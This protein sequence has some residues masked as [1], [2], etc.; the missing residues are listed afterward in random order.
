MFV[1]FALFVFRVLYCI[2]QASMRCKLLLILF[3]FFRLPDATVWRVIRAISDAARSASRV[4]IVA[5]IPHSQHYRRVEQ[6]GSSPGLC[7]GGR[8]LESCPCNFTVIIS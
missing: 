5:L 3:V 7:P 2:L 4:Q 1:L 6:F 8:R